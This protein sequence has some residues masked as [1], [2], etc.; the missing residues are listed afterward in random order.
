M[1]CYLDILSILDLR[2]IKNSKLNGTINWGHWPF[3]VRPLLEI[4]TLIVL[5][6]TPFI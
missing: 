5:S 6:I 4:L 1:L 2:T 3:K